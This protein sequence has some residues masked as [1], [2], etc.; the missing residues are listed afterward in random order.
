MASREFPGYGASPLNAH[1]IGLCVHSVTRRTSG[2][3]WHIAEASNYDF[4]I[5]S[6]QVSRT[7]QNVAYWIQ[8][9]RLFH[10]RNLAK[11]IFHGTSRGLDYVI[12]AVSKIR[13]VEYPS[14]EQY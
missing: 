7:R 2:G 10:Q 9:T 3:I 12:V 11:R 5:Y 4:L 13:A 6:S 1:D 14:L 8:I